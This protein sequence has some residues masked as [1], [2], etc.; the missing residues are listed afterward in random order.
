MSLNIHLLNAYHI[1]QQMQ[2]QLFARFQALNVF[3]KLR[4]LVCVDKQWY[5]FPEKKK[6]IFIQHI[7]YI[8]ANVYTFRDLFLNK[9]KKKKS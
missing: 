2:H 3:L 7:K 6:S 9:N 1:L 4:S 5:Q 8:C